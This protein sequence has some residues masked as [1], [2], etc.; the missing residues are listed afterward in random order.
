MLRES[1]KRI[2]REQGLLVE[3]LSGKE[4]D[5]VIA[6]VYTRFVRNNPRALWLDFRCEASQLPYTSSIMEELAV[7]IPPDVIVYCLLD[8]FNT[9]FH[10]LKGTIADVSLVL[11]SS[12]EVDEYY[13]VYEDFSILY[14]ETDHDDLL[15]IDCSVNLLRD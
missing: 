13:V 15:Y 5:T 10:V 14:C 6:E 3:F 12:E 4:S 7:L 9:E 8:D 11:L 1:L 2:I